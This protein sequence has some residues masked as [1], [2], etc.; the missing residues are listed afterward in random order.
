MDISLFLSK[1]L[2]LYFVVFSLGM[3]LNAK[4]LKPLLMKIL[5]TPAL[6]FI[7]GL[8][9]LILGILILVGHNIWEANW[10]L[11]IT[12][13][14]WLALVKGVILVFFPQL[15]VTTSKKW[16]QNKAAYY[17]TSGILFLIGIYLWYI[18][19]FKSNFF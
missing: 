7:S 1:A 15:L 19:Y 18:G 5:D 6:L 14:G 8:V 10:K 12:L 13:S 3:L 9:A 11:I 4:R 16:L 17:S 2:G